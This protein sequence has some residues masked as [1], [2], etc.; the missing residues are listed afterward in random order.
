M[1]KASM[2][3]GLFLVISGEVAGLRSQN[4]LVNCKDEALQ[5]SVSHYAEVY[6]RDIAIQWIGD[7]PA[8]WPYPH[9]VNVSKAAPHGQ[10]K[11]LLFFTHQLEVHNEDESQILYSTLPHEVCHSVIGTV[12]GLRV[13][14]WASEGIAMM[15]ERTD[16]GA[17]DNARFA[18]MVE[19]TP[20]KV[21]F[22]RRDYPIFFK[23]PFYGQA[24]SV[25]VFLVEKSDKKTFLRFVQEGNV[26]GWDKALAETYKVDWGTLQV[27]W[28][29]WHQKRFPKD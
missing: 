10:N 27:D 21:M 15:C 17:S 9:I 12:C 4:F 14:L 13:P 20:L 8:N 24:Y 25:T 2:V 1:T 29:A 23:N 16:M 7:V 3:W 22:L 18:R 28:W 26:N 11:N 19:D 5:A 6:R